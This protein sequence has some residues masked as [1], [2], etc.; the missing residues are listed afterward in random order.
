MS[1]SAPR[2]ISVVW[3]LLAAVAVVA[4]V[5]AESVGGPAMPERAGD[6]VAGLALVGGGAVAWICRPRAGAGPLML[7]SG[8]SWFAGDLSSALLYA[9][10]GP[11]VHLLL[12]YPSG[13]ASSRVTILVIAAAYADGLIPDLARSEWATLALMSAVPSRGRRRRAAGARRRPRR[14][15]SAERDARSGRA[16][17]AARCGRR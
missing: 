10:R 3:G 9:H 14:C 13:R 16:R 2:L 15:R 8:L 6:L 11:L 7:A 12:T 4:A 5:G 17:P 1:L